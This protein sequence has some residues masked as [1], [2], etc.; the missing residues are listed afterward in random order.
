MNFGFCGIIRIPRASLSNATE[1]PKVAKLA[2][3]EGIAAI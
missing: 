3:K 2:A 1:K